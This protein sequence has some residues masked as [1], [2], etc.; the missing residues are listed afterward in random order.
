MGLPLL[1]VSSLEVAPTRRQPSRISGI[2][3]HV[4]A[5]EVVGLAGLMGSGRSELLMHLY[6]AWG[7]RRGGS[8]RLL[9]KPYDDPTP[10]RSLARGLALLSEDRR[11][12]GLIPD[13]SV[14]FNLT[15]SALARLNRRG[16]LDTAEEARLYRQT[17][18]ALHVRAHDP[19][20]PIHGLSGGNQQKVLI[21]RALLTDPRVILLDEP[22]RGVDVATKFEIYELINRLTDQGTAVLLATSELPE[23]L[24]LSDRVLVLRGGRIV[25]ELASPPFDQE[26]V[27]AAALGHDDRS[28]EES[29]IDALRGDERRSPD[30]G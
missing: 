25:I 23:L 15:L 20:A 6:G 22:T 21:G 7:V 3:F 11:R 27:L 18:A 24:G 19:E 17:A 1:D 29:R 5:G 30:H 9:G 10:S 13:R 28:A 26:R 4:G 14:E 8:V 16:V 12:F 2:S